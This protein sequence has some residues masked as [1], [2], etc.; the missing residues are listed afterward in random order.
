MIY[1]SVDKGAV[2]GSLSN[3]SS[4]ISS[5]NLLPDE[6]AFGWYAE[7]GYQV[8]PAWWLDVRYDRLDRGTKI[9]SNERRFTILTLGTHYYFTPDLRLMFNY[10]IRDNEAPNLDDNDP[11]N[12]I[13]DAHDNRFSAQLL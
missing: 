6:D 9:S 7:L 3:N 13:F 1:N 8:L 10:E 2:P 12:L 4:E 5:Y 11:P